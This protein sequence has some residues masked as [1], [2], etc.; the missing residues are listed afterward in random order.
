VHKPIPTRYYMLKRKEKED[1][2]A[3]SSEEDN[4]SCPSL[5]ERAVTGITARED[6]DRSQ[7]PCHTKNY[8]VSKPERHTQT[9][10]VCKSRHKKCNGAQPRCKI[11]SWRPR[12]PNCEN[13]SKPN[14]H[15]RIEQCQLCRTSR[16]KA[17]MQS[18]LQLQRLSH[19][20]QELP[21]VSLKPRLGSR[22]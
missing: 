6:L 18:A 17:A 5:R 12:L 21:V 2:E 7:L 13:L 11:V 16:H 10:N 20:S 9:Y 15:Q 1:A 14:P 22:S 8:R 3:I 4:D 19:I